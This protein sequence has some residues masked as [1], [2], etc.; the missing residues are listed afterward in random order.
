MYFGAAELRFD[1][2]ADKRAGIRGEALE[3]PAQNIVDGIAVLLGRL[4]FGAPA[5]LQRPVK[6]A[7]FRAPHRSRSDGRGG[8]GR[9]PAKRHGGFERVEL[10]AKIQ[11]RVWGRGRCA[12]RAEQGADDHRHGVSPA[13]RHVAPR[14]GSM[15]PEG[16][17]GDLAPEPF[18]NI[19]ARSEAQRQ[20][21]SRLGRALRNRGPKPEVEPVFHEREALTQPFQQGAHGG[22][23]AAA[24]IDQQFCARREACVWRD[25]ALETTLHGF[26]QGL[27]HDPPS[28]Y[29]PFGARL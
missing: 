24:P 14:A 8:A 12:Q 5:R 16:K 13:L 6:Q 28:R 20:P 23:V 29:V 10:H 9:S 11:Q 17:L 15:G 25:P 27:R 2:T 4:L 18:P 7:S 1:K 22:R 19:S 26:T 21:L 3:P